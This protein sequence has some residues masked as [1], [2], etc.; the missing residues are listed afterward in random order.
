MARFLA[1]NEKTKQKLDQV[2]RGSH[3]KSLPLDEDDDEFLKANYDKEDYILLLQEGEISIEKVPQEY[4]GDDEVMLEAVKACGVDAL[5]YALKSLC[6]DKTFINKILHM[7]NDCGVLDYTSNSLRSSL[8]ASYIEECIA[9]GKAK[10]VIDYI[11]VD[12]YKQYL[13]DLINQCNPSDIKEMIEKIP[14]GIEDVELAKELLKSPEDYGFSNTEAVLAYILKDT[15]KEIF[16]D[17]LQ[18]GNWNG[19]YIKD[20]DI[21]IFTEIVKALGKGFVDDKNVAIGL[22][23]KRFEL[24]EDEDKVYDLIDLSLF[25]DKEFLLALYEENPYLLGYVEEGFD[26]EEEKIEFLQE[27]AEEYVE[28]RKKELEEYEK[29]QEKKNNLAD[30]ES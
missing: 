20:E 6:N 5:K 2:V 14:G 1:D 7:T 11:P 19:Y 8:L 28:E 29:A 12:M 24:F 26:N 27:R 15:R 25:K 4:R 22:I 3:S 13:S 17:C 21:Q 18:I 23:E 30:P 9:K 10:K 16:Y